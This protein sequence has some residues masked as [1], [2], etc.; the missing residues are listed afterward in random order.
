MTR[1]RCLRPRMS[2]I[3]FIS[4]YSDAP[5]VGAESGEV[6]AADCFEPAFFAH[7]ASPPNDSMP[8]FCFELLSPFDKLPHEP[9]RDARNPSKPGKRA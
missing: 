2:V 4:I 5:A 6:L 1:D 8:R 3:G 9:S 7:S